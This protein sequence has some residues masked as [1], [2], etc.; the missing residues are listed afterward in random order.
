MDKEITITQ[1]DGTIYKVTVYDSSE[2]TGT[3]NLHIYYTDESG[4]EKEGWIKL[5]STS[6]HG[7]TE[8]NLTPTDGDKYQILDGVY[9]SAT[10]KQNGDIQ[11][12]H[13]YT[14]QKE[15]GTD[16]ISDFYAKR[17]TT[18]DGEVVS[19]NPSYQAGDLIVK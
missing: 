19:N 13:V 4:L 11:T 7:T 10:V 6:D 14:P 8:A 9:Y 3:P 16:N 18:Y 5:G 1:D 12:I 15:G 2:I 17:G